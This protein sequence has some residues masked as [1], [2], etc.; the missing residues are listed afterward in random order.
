LF[1]ITKIPL[2]PDGWGASGLQIARRLLK[3][4]P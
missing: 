2:L 3:L 1:F 4:Q